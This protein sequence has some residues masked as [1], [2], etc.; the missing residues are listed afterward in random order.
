MY[1]YNSYLN[2]AMQQRPSYHVIFTIAK[3]EF[4][5]QSVNCKFNDRILYAILKAM[6]AHI[7]SVLSP[8]QVHK[9]YPDPT[10]FLHVRLNRTDVFNCFIFGRLTS[11][12]VEIE[13]RKDRTWRPYSIY[14]FSFSTSSST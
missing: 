6:F 2:Q 7:L 1:E 14:T 13:T 9:S 5:T 11:L 10:S 3:N 12:L 4:P 8:R